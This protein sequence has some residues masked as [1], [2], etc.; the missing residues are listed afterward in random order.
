VNKTKEINDVLKFLSKKLR[1]YEI[2]REMLIKE[3]FDELKIDYCFTY[4]GEIVWEFA[5]AFRYWRVLLE[6]DSR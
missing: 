5:D 1:F 2:E 3:I 4:N 6:L